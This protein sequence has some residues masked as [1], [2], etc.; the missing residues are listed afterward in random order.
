MPSPHFS[1]TLT[2]HLDLGTGHF[3]FATTKTVDI[4]CLFVEGCFFHPAVYKGL[5]YASQPELSTK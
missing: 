1:S 3:N 5:G 2:G 4:L